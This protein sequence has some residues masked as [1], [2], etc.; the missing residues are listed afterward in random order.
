[1]TSLAFEGSES[2]LDGTSPKGICVG[3]HFLTLGVSLVEG[4]V[5]LVEV[6]VLSYFGLV[7]FVLGTVL[8]ENDS[9][10]TLGLGSVVS[11]L[12]FAGI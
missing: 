7:I 8:V 5:T 11:V 9:F 3:L 1:M 10:G 2:S 12:L 6:K 4:D